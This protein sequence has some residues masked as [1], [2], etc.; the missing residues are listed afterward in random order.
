MDYVKADKKRPIKFGTFAIREF[1]KLK[2]LSFDGA[3]DY[4]N[5]EENLDTED[6]ILLVYCGF[7]YGAKKEKKDV[8]FTLDDLWMWVD[9]NPALIQDAT[10][11]WQESVP[12]GKEGSKKKVK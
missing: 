6:V 7:I 5:K 11:V 4:M 10:K 1:A 9:E 3:L 12:E 2:G 8:D